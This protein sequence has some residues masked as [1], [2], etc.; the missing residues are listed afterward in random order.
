LRT[1]NIILML[2]ELSFTKR[3]GLETDNHEEYKKPMLTYLSAAGFLL[4]AICFVLWIAPHHPGDFVHIP[5]KTIKH[6]AIV[7][8]TAVLIGIAASTFI[9]LV[10]ITII[11]EATP[12][13]YPK[14]DRLWATTLWLFFAAVFIAPLLCWAAQGKLLARWMPTICCHFCEKEIELVDNWQCPGQCR[15][16]YRHVLSP[17]RTCNTRMKGMVCSYCR[18]QIIFEDSHNELEVR[19]RG[20][21]RIAQPNPYFFG[22]LFLLYASL[23]LFYYCWQ[24]GAK[25]QYVC[26]C[27]AG[28]AIIALIF[29]RPK[30]LVANPYYTEGIVQWLKSVRK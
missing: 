24:V 15:P 2:T 12:F 30:R 7:K 14:T 29:H 17:C 6:L 23:V 10:T 5:S 18:R 27:F 16:T 19:N 26:P 11:G 13:L 3:Y 22:A 1:T 8:I 9:L 20:N 28:A 25:G 4:S 21:R